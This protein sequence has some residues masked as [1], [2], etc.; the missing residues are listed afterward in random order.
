[1]GKHI[2]RSEYELIIVNDGSKDNSLEIAQH[3][4]SKYTNIR[5]FSQ[6][7]AGLSVARNFGITKALGDY[8]WFVDSDDWIK[9]NCLGYIKQRI[10]GDNIDVASIMAAKVYA[11]DERCYY[12][13]EDNQFMTGPDSL[14]MMKM[15]CA[16]FYIW[17]RNYLQ[18]K[19]FRFVLVFFTK[20]WSLLLELFI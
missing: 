16:P 17:R 10:S 15:P 1:M 13:L 12:H 8:I 5:V 9:D 3:L 7:N 6:E 19:N 14:K 18:R 4:Q 2:D 11:K 20:I